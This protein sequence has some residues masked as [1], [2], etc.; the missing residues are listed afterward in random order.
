MYVGRGGG[1]GEFFFFFFLLETSSDT[2]QTRLPGNE[3]GV[4]IQSVCSVGFVHS[5]HVHV[6][7]QLEL[8]R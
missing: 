5:E 3:D 6:L 2:G 8:T 1:Q 4:G 7:H